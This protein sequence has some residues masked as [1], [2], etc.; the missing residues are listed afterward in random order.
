MLSSRIQPEIA[1]TLTSETP[2]AFSRLP[3][4]HGGL[5]MDTDKFTVVDPALDDHALF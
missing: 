3:L 5:A 2:A 1:G 4:V